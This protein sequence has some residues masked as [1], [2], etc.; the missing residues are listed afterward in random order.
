MT[1]P[2]DTY[3]TNKDSELVLPA[4]GEECQHLK[5]VPTGSHEF[6][7]ELPGNMDGIVVSAADFGFNESNEN[8]GDALN[9]ALEHC[10]HLW[11][12]PLSGHVHALLMS[13]ILL[14]H[15]VSVN[16]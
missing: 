1:N 6:E 2:V 16:C 10:T 13:I 7:V 14:V 3:F 12:Q 11:P 8:Y 4:G 9:K 15:A 5:N